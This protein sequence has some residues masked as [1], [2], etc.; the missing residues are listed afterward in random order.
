MAR[1]RSSFGAATEKSSNWW[2]TGTYPMRLYHPGA[3]ILRRLKI[4]R[5]EAGELNLS[6]S[7]ERTS[8]LSRCDIQRPTKLLRPPVR[9]SPGG[10][11]MRPQR[12]TLTANLEPLVEV[13]VGRERST[14]VAAD[15][16]RQV[17][18][19]RLAMTNWSFQARIGSLRQVARRADGWARLS[20]CCL[21]GDHGQHHSRCNRDEGRSCS[22]TSGTDC[23]N[24]CVTLLHRILVFNRKHIR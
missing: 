1:L 20:R 9:G 24:G 2:P 13:P 17:R 5:R 11:R 16:R 21:P 12:S 14:F 8:A 19:P 4:C 3:E 18:R 15:I 10:R 7:R 6:S 22:V 23:S